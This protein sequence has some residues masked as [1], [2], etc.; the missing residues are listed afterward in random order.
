M[1]LARNFVPIVW[2]TDTDF[3][4]LAGRGGPTDADAALTIHHVH[5]RDGGQRPVVRAHAIDANTLI[6]PA[7]YVARPATAAPLLHARDIKVLDC[8]GSACQV[9]IAWVPTQGLRA[10]LLDVTF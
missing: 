5:V 4:F 7:A 2:A 10:P 1:W 8:A 6:D 3:V 9:Q